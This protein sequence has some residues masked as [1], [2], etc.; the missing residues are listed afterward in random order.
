MGKVYIERV[1]HPPSFPNATV[2][3]FIPIEKEHL[4][5]GETKVVGIVED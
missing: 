5:P 2:V 3:R 4:G 1:I